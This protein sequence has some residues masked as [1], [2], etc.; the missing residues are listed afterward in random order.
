MSLTTGEHGLLEHAERIAAFRAGSAG[1]TGGL[2]TTSVLLASARTW[3]GLLSSAQRRDLDAICRKLALSGTLLDRYAPDWKPTADRTPLSDDTAHLLVATLLAWAGSPDQLGQDGRG[4]SAKL[5]NAAL[6]ALDAFPAVNAALGKQAEGQLRDL[7]PASITGERVGTVPAL[8]VQP[9]TLP[10]TVLAYEGPC[11][12]AYLKMMQ[13][14]G[15]RAERLILLVLDRHPASHKPV[16]RW[17]PGRLRGWY[18]EKTQE[19][20]LNHWP[21]RIRTAHPDLLQAVVAGL[22]PV[23]DRPA[24]LIESMYGPLGLQDHADR[25]DRL[26]VRDLRD[27]RLRDALQSLGPTTL[28]FTGGGI[29]PASIIDLPGLRFLHVHPGR[30]PLVRGADGLLWSTLLQGRPSMSCFHLAGGLDTGDVIAIRDYPPLTF[31]LHDPGRP[32]DQTLYRALFSFVD[33]LL[34]ADL[35]VRDVLAAGGDPRR[36]PATAQ[37]AGRGVTYHFMHPHLRARVLSGLFPRA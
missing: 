12:R 6:V 1:D 5:L 3:P 31:P 21:R 24:Q 33:P 10:L 28:L 36:W 29:L 14:A 7:S 18:A 35:L 16:G 4:F 13:R 34:R 22:G 8:A 26:V 2:D 17:F 30:L 11:L 27:D 23:I 20:A 32:D 15:L 19:L 9:R 25:V 37:D